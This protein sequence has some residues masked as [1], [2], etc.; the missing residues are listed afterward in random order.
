MQERF[1]QSFTFRESLFHASS[2]RKQDLEKFPRQG[3]SQDR[4]ED[5]SNTSLVS[6]PKPTPLEA[7]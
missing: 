5:H 3:M 4:E 7:N 1:Y 6:S 2:D